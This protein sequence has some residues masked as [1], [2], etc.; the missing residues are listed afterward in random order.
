MSEVAWHPL[1]EQPEAAPLGFESAVFALICSHSIELRVAAR[2][3]K[4]QAGSSR[5]L[6]DEHHY[7]DP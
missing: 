3:S 4:P 6:A 5:F 2:S 7:E 1:S